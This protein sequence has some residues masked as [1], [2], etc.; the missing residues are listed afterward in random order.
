M[1]NMKNKIIIYYSL[2]AILW[3][4]SITSQKK[5]IN[6]IVEKSIKVDSTTDSNLQIGM[7]EAHFFDQLVNSE[8]IEIEKTSS[9]F[10]LPIENARRIIIQ[11]DSCI[12]LELMEPQR[13]KIQRLE[14]TNEKIKII[15][16]ENDWHYDATL[17]D[18]D[19]QLYKW[20]YIY[21]DSIW[22]DVSYYVI[23][24]KFVNKLKKGSPSNMPNLSN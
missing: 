1:M 18:E 2:V 10:C 11:G 22:E 24:K 14:K 17:I 19:R 23:N 8:F 6:Q 9:D 15:F 12:I 13:L 4:C 21:D 3:G 7:R 5:E 16:K 20:E